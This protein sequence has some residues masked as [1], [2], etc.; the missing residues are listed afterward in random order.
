[1]VFNTMKA[2]SFN[3][4]YFRTLSNF[5]TRIH[6]H[7][8][9]RKPSLVDYIFSDRAARLAFSGQICWSL[10]LNYCPKI[11]HFVIA[12]KKVFLVNL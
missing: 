7:V 9:E 4:I 6:L 5:N 3:Y 11:C 10:N 8:V 12:E 2:E 1:M